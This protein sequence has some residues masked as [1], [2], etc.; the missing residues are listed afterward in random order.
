MQQQQQECRSRRNAAAHIVLLID[1][2]FRVN[3]GGWVWNTLSVSRLPHHPHHH[4]PH[5]HDAGCCTHRLYQS[6]R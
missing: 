6:D 1:R 4:H 2:I 3:E 5:H